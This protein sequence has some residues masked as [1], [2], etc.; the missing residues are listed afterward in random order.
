MTIGTRIQ[1]NSHGELII[2]RSQDVAPIL[3]RNKALAN[4]GDG[5]SASRDIRRVAS[6]PLVLVE[7]WKNEEGID[8]FNPDH[9]PAVRRKLNSPEYQYLRTAPG[10]L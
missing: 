7:K 6:I 5:Y 9:L 4:D 3:D 8:L 10:R 1:E 2:Q